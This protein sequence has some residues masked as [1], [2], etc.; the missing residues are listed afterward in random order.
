MTDADLATA[1]ERAQEEIKELRARI[2]EMQMERDQ[3]VY[4]R[5]LKDLG[6]I[7]GIARIGTAPRWTGPMLHAL[8]RAAQSIAFP[9]GVK[10]EDHD[11]VQ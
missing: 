7:I 1:L 4:L 2:V 10:E 8:R 3:G 6:I 5:D 11:R 9:D